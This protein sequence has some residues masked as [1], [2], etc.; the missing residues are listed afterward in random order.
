[1]RSMLGEFFQQPFMLVVGLLVTATLGV[2]VDSY[3]NRI[4]TGFRLKPPADVPPETW[5]ALLES[6]ETY[7]G[8]VHWLGFME[9][10]FFVTF[11]LVSAWQFI[12]GWLFFKLGCYWGIWHGLAK[13]G[14][15]GSQTK[16][17]DLMI[18]QSRRANALT[19]TCLFSTLGN[20]LA[21]VLGM[22]V[23]MLVMGLWY[24]AR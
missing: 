1:M 15:F 21:A 20:L 12:L 2:L 9:R 8:G 19:L 4:L 7:G 16:A 11:L 22:M 3:L 10:L 23:A 6:P 14:D 24:K 18:A 17:T 5:E 13:A